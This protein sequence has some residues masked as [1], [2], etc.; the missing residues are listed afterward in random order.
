MGDIVEPAPQP[1]S[2]PGTISMTWTD[3]CGEEVRD[4]NPTNI[5]TW[6]FVEEVFVSAKLNLS[7]DEARAAA[8]AKPSTPES[9]GPLP[10]GSDFQPLDSHTV[11][12]F[13]AFISSFLSATKMDK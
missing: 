10:R 11:H 1:G 5:Q 8:P 6:G 4:E 3:P 7:S 9:S 12:S 2:V 13:T